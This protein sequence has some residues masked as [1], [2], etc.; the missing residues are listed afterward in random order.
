V[1]PANALDSTA[2]TTTLGS[3]TG[4]DASGDWTLF[5]ADVEA[6]GTN[7]L[8][9]WELEIS[10]QTE[11][12]TTPPPNLVIAEQSNGTYLIQFDGVPGK[13]YRIEFSATLD[14]AAWEHLGSA[15]VDP[16]GMFQFLDSPPIGTPAR[17]YRSIFP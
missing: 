14:P 11:S 13:T 6:G 8:V 9:G 10:G 16:F 5:L 17:F 3:F 1:D 4:T 2:E 7:M 15:T 12:P